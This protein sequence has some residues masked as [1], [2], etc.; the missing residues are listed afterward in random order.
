MGFE[1][2]GRHHGSLVR[3]RTSSYFNP[4]HPEADGS[5]VSLLATLCRGVNDDKGA[6]LSDETHSS[7]LLSSAGKSV[8]KNAQEHATINDHLQS[9]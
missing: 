1:L 4:S 5:A 7:N 2:T 6:S 9:R 3:W 8:Y